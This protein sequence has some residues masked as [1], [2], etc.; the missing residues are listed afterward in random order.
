MR[1]LKQYKRIW[2]ILLV[3]ILLSGIVGFLERFFFDEAKKWELQRKGAGEGSYQAMMK[4]DVEG[5][6]ENYDYAIEVK[7]QCLSEK[8]KRE[9]LIA[10]EKELMAE[11]PGENEAMDCIREKVKIKETYQNG[12]VNAEWL[13]DD[14]SIMDF[15]GNVIAKEIPEDG[16][17][18]GAQAELTCQDAHTSVQFAFRVFPTKLSEQ[19]QFLKELKKELD[20]Q[21]EE[22]GTAILPL[23]EQLNGYEIKWQEEQSHS[24]VKILFLGLT[25]AGSM[26]LLERSRRME[27]QKQREKRLF[28]EYPDMVSKLSIL[29]GSGMTLRGAWMR[30]ASSYEKKQKENP[31]Q[32]A[33]VYEEMRITCHELESGMGEERA[34][35]RFGE[36]CG[37]ARYRK[38]GNMLAQNLRKGDQSILRFLEKEA[39]DSFWERKEIARRYGEEAGTKLLAP[40]MLMLGMILLLLIVP[41]MMTFQL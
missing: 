8:E 20:R 30:I 14:Y 27:A 36:R 9:S 19:E 23:P 40:M 28:L 2:Q 3:T 6:L 37:G 17:V 4:I 10:A 5:L 26:P 32:K 38:L 41:A 33:I 31:S 25:V 39:E 21:Q 22:D 35:R 18:V 29:L 11:F 15:E 13:F 24:A 16:V 34:Y 12:L 1:R 7:E